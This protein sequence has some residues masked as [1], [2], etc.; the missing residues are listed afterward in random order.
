MIYDTIE[1]QAAPFCYR[2]EFFRPN[3]TGKRRQRN[4]ENVSLSDA[5]RP[6]NDGKIQCYQTI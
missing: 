2:L 6:A 3:Y 4:G 1:F 5:G